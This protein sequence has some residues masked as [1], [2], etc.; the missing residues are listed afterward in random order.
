MA[1]KITFTQKEESALAAVIAALPYETPE[2]E[3]IIRPLE[4]LYAKMQVARTK[5]STAFHGVGVAKVLEMARNKFGDRF[6]TPNMITPQWTIKMQKAINDSG[7]TEATATRAIEN[8]NWPGD[9]FAQTFLY[10]LAELAVMAPKQGILFNKKQ[11]GPPAPSK[12]SGWLG[13]LDEE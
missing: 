8:C 10:K 11:P 12:K 1:A 5:E 2:F 7:V 9:I 6:K 13:K 3:K 4:A